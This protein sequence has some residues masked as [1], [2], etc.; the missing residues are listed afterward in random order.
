MKPIR[1]AV[2]DEDR[3]ARERILRLLRDEDDIQIVGWQACS[4]DAAACVR[5][6]RPN[7]IFLNI[8]TPPVGRCSIREAVE[9]PDELAI[10][11]VTTYDRSMVRIL[12]W[13]DMN[14]LLKPFD[15]ERFRRALQRAKAGIQG[16]KKD[17]TRRDSR[18]P[19]RSTLRS[20]TDWNNA[21][22][23]PQIFSLL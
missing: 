5:E 18:H 8:H 7:L 1:V 10:I 21:L 20:G 2:F 12:D 6:T 14:Y 22:A 13:Y 4:D 19:W 23:S 3:L 15:A 11:Y 9:S 16:R 17:Y